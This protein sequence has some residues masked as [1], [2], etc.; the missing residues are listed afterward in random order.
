[1]MCFGW[2]SA[3][4]AYSRMC[5]CA[6]C[7]GIPLA[8]MRYMRACMSFINRVCHFDIIFFLLSLSLPPGP[9]KMSRIVLARIAGAKVMLST[10]MAADAKANV[11]STQAA[12]ISA[13]LKR[14]KL[15]AEMTADVMQRLMEIDWP[16]RARDELLASFAAPESRISSVGLS[17]RQ[18]RNFGAPSAQAKSRNCTTSLVLGRLRNSNACRTKSRPSSSR[19]AVPSGSVTISQSL[20]RPCS[21]RSRWKPRSTTTAKS[22]CRCECGKHVVLTPAQLENIKFVHGFNCTEDGL[23]NDSELIRLFDPLQRSIYDWP[24]TIFERWRKPNRIK[25]FVAMLAE[26]ERHHQKPTLRRSL[27]EP[28][29]VFRRQHQ[30]K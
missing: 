8:R 27:N 11:A 7:S 17:I 25:C 18:R 20:R 19:I 26:K 6:F 5:T 23:L 1:M 24:H 12:A 30:A 22:F 28:T 15:D 16:P 21:R 13:E 2:C 4:D 29:C 9:C 14:E 10:T 3:H